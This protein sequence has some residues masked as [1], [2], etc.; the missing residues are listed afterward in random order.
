MFPTPETSVHVRTAY[1]EREKISRLLMDNQDSASFVRTLK[2]LHLSCSQIATHEVTHCDSWLYFF[3]A[4]VGC[5]M[6]RMQKRIKHVD[7]ILCVVHFSRFTDVH[8]AGFAMFARFSLVT[9]LV[10]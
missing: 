10:V 7:Y 8:S 1:R 6:E 5:G 2:C 4:N 3:C 9:N